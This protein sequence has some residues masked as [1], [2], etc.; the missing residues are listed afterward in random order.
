MIGVAEGLQGSGDVFIHQ[1]RRRQMT[2]GKKTKK[3]HSK[4]GG[5]VLS[6][7]T[8]LHQTALRHQRLKSVNV[9]ALARSNELAVTLAS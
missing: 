6:V 1:E 8:K 9:F 2:E 7:C 5:Y 4:T 3:K